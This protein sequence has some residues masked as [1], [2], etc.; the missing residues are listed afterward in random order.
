MQN[1]KFSTVELNQPIW[2]RTQLNVE[3][4]NP[5]KFVVWEIREPENPKILETISIS[6]VTVWVSWFWKFV[7]KE[8]LHMICSDASH[9]ISACQK[10]VRETDKHLTT[11]WYFRDQLLNGQT[12]AVCMCRVQNECIISLLSFGTFML[13]CIFF[14]MPYNIQLH[15]RKHAF[16]ST[17]L[18]EWFAWKKNPKHQ[19][20]FNFSL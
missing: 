2:S 9:N 19:N 11:I 16:T 15:V 1:F 8:H 12:V 18:N 13:E 20:R 7:K 3:S 6:L 17:M 4:K 5:E 10:G 14:R